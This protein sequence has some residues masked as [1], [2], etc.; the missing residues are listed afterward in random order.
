MDIYDIVTSIAE[1]CMN[2]YFHEIDFHVKEYNIAGCKVKVV[3]SEYSGFCVNT[4]LRH[5]DYIIDDDA[6]YI[7]EFIIDVPEHGEH[8]VVYWS[9]Y[10]D[11][12]MDFYY[13]A[14]V[15]GE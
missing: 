9:P 1:Y 8:S 2:R 3:K 10:N 7:I 12:T 5:K 13:L 15:I 11:H 6:K 14:E 4:A